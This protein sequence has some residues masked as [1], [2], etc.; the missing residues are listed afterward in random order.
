M[1]KEKQALDFIPLIAFV[2][3]D[4]V[5]HQ[6]INKIYKTNE[7][8]FNVESKK[9]KYY[10]CFSSGSAIK[11]LYYHRALGVLSSGELEKKETFNILKKV[12]K[13]ECTYCKNLNILKLS[14][15]YN[16]L[17][18]KNRG[19]ITINNL[20]NRLIVIIAMCIIND[21]KI[22]T[23]DECF[24]LFL[25]SMV[26]ILKFEKDDERKIN[27]NKA[28][29]E[30][31]NIVFKQLKRLEKEHPYLLSEGTEEKKETLDE[32][33]EAIKFIFDIFNL[34]LLD[35]SNDIEL[36]DNE[37]SSIIYCYLVAHEGIIEDTNDLDDW[38][39]YSIKLAYMLKAYN[40]SKDY[41]LNNNNEELLLKIQELNNKNKQLN[42]KLK[43]AN[44]KINS[45]EKENKSI[46]TENNRLKLEIEKLNKDKKEINS[47][48]EYIF[49]NS[50]E[51][52]PNTINELDIDYIINQLNE[53]DIV[54]IG[55]NQNWINKIKEV[56]PN[57]IYIPAD[58]I[59]FDIKLLK[60]KYILFNT[61][62]VSHSMYYRI[63]E[64]INKAK[65]FNFFSGST[66]IDLSIKKIYD[67]YYK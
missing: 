54:V 57:W 48:R 35:L 34:S 49:N 14:D 11:Q 61:D 32:N 17:M 4:E 51:E 60:N 42:D 29:Q 1:N 40:I 27:Y 66:N 10:N 53:L 58:S 15:Y 50:I 52:N 59:N 37:V 26:N 30:D 8:L 16:K 44:D 31:K 12:Y 39:D 47:L 43:L 63:I 36:T 41:I 3:S 13:Y 33:K 25:T 46:I 2:L 28:K 18:K 62:Y 64:N 21:I 22:D 23:Q 19:F 24:K 55:G 7:L 5:F 45:L 56:L 67:I 65:Q 38:L 20:N 9:N 6:D